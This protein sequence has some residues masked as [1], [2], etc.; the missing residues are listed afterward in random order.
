VLREKIPTEISS[1][2]VN[3]LAC[4]LRNKNPRVSGRD[5]CGISSS[6]IGS[7]SAGFEDFDIT[8]G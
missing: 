1:K 8:K 3:L 5:I 7:F 2:F 4:N 6:I